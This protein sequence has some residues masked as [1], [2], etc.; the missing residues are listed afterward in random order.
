M[1]AYASCLS[2]SSQSLEVVIEWSAFIP[3]VHSHMISI[4]VQ[5][6]PAA[7]RAVKV[8]HCK[9]T[10]QWNHLYITCQT[11]VQLE[12]VVMRTWSCCVFYWFSISLQSDPT[13]LWPSLVLL[14]RTFQS[15]L[16]FTAGQ[17]CDTLLG[18]SNNQW[19]K[20]DHIPVAIRRTAPM[21]LWKIQQMY[22]TQL[23]W[24]FCMKV[25]Q[26]LFQK[27]RS[28]ISPSPVWTG[29]NM[30]LRV[31]TVA[32]VATICQDLSWDCLLSF[33]LSLFYGWTCRAWCN[34]SQFIERGK[35]GNCW[36][37]IRY[38]YIPCNHRWGPRVLENSQCGFS[39][40]EEQ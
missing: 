16:V 28:A 40:Q 5:R 34:Q 27:G 2:L 15:K 31:L 11:F 6:F 9:H 10:W 12:V 36:C 26:T 17:F 21:N 24:L 14:V 32:A 37:L 39:V 3:R 8:L 20:Q 1:A 25:C 23:V 13:V 22:I 7:P 38:L 30:S 35:K 19:S 4:A 18:Q 29:L 33:I